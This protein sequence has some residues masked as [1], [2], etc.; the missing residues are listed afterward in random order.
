MF[1]KNSGQMPHPYISI[2]LKHQ[3]YD[4]LKRASGPGHFQPFVL[5]QKNT[6][7]KGSMIGIILNVGF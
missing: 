7:K 2:N 1:S 5:Q 4:D 6:I 3:K